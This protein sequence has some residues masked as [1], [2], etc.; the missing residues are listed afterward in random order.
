MEMALPREVTTVCRREA[1]ISTS[2]DISNR[3]TMS[4]LVDVDLAN[5]M[6]A[7]TPAE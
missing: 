1:P 5:S 6:R 7:I 3:S 4:S 2:V